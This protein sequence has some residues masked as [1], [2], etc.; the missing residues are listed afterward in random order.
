MNILYK[1]LYEFKIICKLNYSVFKNFIKKIY[2]Y[3][4]INSTKKLKKKNN[5][6]I[7][8]KIDIKKICF[9]VEFLDVSKI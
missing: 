8:E 1:L 9:I 4:W 2:H 6:G 7:Q 3:I 5:K